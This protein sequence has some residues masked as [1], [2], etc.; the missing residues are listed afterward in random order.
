MKELQQ[1]EL[2][3][4]IKFIDA[5]GCKYKIITDDGQEF[6]E[7]DVAEKKELKRHLKRPYGELAKYYK[8]K[9]NFD[10]AV[11]EVQEVDC[12]DILPNE[13]R[14]AICSHLGKE[15]GNGTYATCIKDGKVEILRTA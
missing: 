6:G 2:L 13:L 10:I 1:K 9:L 4:I 3:K 15:W 11:G 7:L 8:N 5:I 14:S 12:G